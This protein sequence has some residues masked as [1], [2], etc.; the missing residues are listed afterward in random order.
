M[1]R[2]VPARTLRRGVVL[3]YGGLAAATAAFLVG[4][5]HGWNVGLAVV[6]AGALAVLL[7]TFA[8]TYVRTGLWRLVHAGVAQL[9]ERETQWTREALLRAYRIVVILSLVL[10]A[11]FSLAIRFAVDL[12]TF[13]GHFSLG[14]ALMMALF[15]LVN[16]LPA[17]LL[18]SRRQDWIVE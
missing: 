4:E 10:I 9:D 15:Y 18:A 8:T 13:R 6:A 7:V 1:E 14:L 2:T 12:L 17:A 5:Y 11:L 16:T 3:N